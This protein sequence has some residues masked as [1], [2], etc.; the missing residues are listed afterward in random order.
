MFELLHQ[1]RTGAE[2]AL[3]FEYRHQFSSK[4]S[5]MELSLIDCQSVTN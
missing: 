3:R 5:V 2:N 4:T 1:G